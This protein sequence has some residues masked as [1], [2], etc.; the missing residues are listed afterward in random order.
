MPPALPPPYIL[1]KQMVVVLPRGAPFNKMKKKGGGSGFLFGFL[2][3][4]HGQNAMYGGE[5]PRRQ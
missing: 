4:G 2:G 1:S 5:M 3:G